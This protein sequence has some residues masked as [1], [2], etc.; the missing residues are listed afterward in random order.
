MYWSLLPTQWCN[1]CPSVISSSQFPAG[2]IMCVL[3]SQK[4]FCTSGNRSC[5]C[6]SS[7]VYPFNR[8]LLYTYLFGRRWSYCCQAS[9]IPAW[10]LVCYLYRNNECLTTINRVRCD[11]CRFDNRRCSIQFHCS[12][13]GCC[14]SCFVFCDNGN[15]I[16]ALF[17]RYIFAEGS[18]IS[19][20]DC[21][22][23][24][25]GRRWLRLRKWLPW[26]ATE[27]AWNSLKI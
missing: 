13:Y 20:G 15:G 25:S 7:L 24:T 19:N 3:S 22:L 6:W 11:S 26:Q 23:Y 2:M 1:V 21:L 18:T 14:L 4:Y 17:Q 12:G 5:I 8:C 27:A 16:A 10:S 9:P